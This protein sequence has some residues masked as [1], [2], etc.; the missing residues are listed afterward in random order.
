MLNMKKDMSGAASVLGL[1]HYLIRSNLKIN[2]RI[3][4]P[5]VENS[6]SGKSF[7][8]GDILISRSGMGLKLKIQMQ[9]AG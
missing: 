5:C 9:R 7:R 2:L 1:A 8:P 3:L 6:V 4:I